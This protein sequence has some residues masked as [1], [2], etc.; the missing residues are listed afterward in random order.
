M[1][2]FDKINEVATEG[3]VNDIKI[4][5]NSM[6]VVESDEH[7]LGRWITKKSKNQIKLFN[8]L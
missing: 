6:L 1:K 8:L 5:S 4:N 7:R 2:K 3:I